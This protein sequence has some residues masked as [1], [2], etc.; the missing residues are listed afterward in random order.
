MLLMLSPNTCVYGMTMCPLVVS[1]PSGSPLLLSLF[2]PLYSLW[3]TASI[4]QDLSLW[5]ASPDGSLCCMATVDPKGVIE[6]SLQ[7]LVLVV[8][9]HWCFFSM[10]VIILIM[11]ITNWCSAYTW[12]HTP[13]GPV[14]L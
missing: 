4:L 8:M 11:V 12:H 2:P 3:K 5:F 6:G 9:L 1:L 7:V 14:E 10:W 13:N